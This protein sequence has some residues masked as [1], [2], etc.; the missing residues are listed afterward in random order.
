MGSPLSAILAE[1]VRF[2][3][4]YDTIISLSFKPLLYYHM[5]AITTSITLV[6][7]VDIKKQV[8]CSDGIKDFYVH[9]FAPIA[10]ASKNMSIN[11]YDVY[12]VQKS[13]LY[14]I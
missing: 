9:V 3:L 2:R 4:E 7:D 10:G 12:F 8:K 14:R 13:F 6:V 1:I 5:D 11:I